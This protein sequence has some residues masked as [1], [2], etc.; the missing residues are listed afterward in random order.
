MGDSW[1]LNLRRDWGPVEA[2]K[3][4]TAAPPGG[5]LAVLMATHN[6]AAFIDSQLQSIADQ[7]WADIDVWASD[8]ASTDATG[9]LL[10]RWQRGWSKG[11]FRIMEGRNA[12]FAENFRSLLT[13]DEVD[14][15]F[16]AFSDQDDIWLPGKIRAAAAAIGAARGPALYCER[17]IITDS[18]GRH[19]LARSPLFTRPAHF[20][21]ALVQNIAGGNTMV[22]NRAAFELVRE[23]ARRTGFVSHDWFCY[24]LVTGAG[25]SVVYS[26]EP[27]V[28]YRQ[29]GANLVG[30]NVGWAA[31]LDRLRRALNGRFVDWNDRNLAALRAC[32]DLL[33]DEAVQTLDAFE[34]ARSGSLLGRLHRLRGSRVYRQTRAGQVSLYAACVLSRL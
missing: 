30:S 4:V 32:E 8:D 17:T 13:L 28:L 12:G 34:A 21:N 1:H 29:H 25:G 2:S 19:E 5:R 9:A 27:H 15:D 26:A 11:R 7:Q 20:R 18:S 33:T 3:D 24:L 23:A 31:R 6:G 16:V 22:L 10:Q 14:A